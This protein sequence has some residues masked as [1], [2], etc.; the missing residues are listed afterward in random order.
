M[1]ICWCWRKRGCIPTV[2]R[3][4]LLPWPQQAT[5]F[6]CSPV[7]D[8]EEVVSALSWGQPCQLPCYSN[9]LITDLLKQWRCGFHLIMLLLLSCVCIDHH[10]VNATNWPTP[11]FL[12]NSRSFY[13]NT[14]FLAVILCTL[15]I[16][17]FTMMLVLTD[18]WAA[19][20]RCWV[21][22]T[23][24]SSSTYPP[25]SAAISWTGLWCAPRTAVSALTACR[26]TQI[27]QTTKLSSARWL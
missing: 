2:M 15:V 16:L 11:C 3:P 23:W 17:T 10:Q 8:L 6:I 21:I 20:G 5:T 13:L 22:T 7:W 9:L 18:K 4:T 26:T 25:I 12:R 24:L 19:W 1:L 27:C 14:P